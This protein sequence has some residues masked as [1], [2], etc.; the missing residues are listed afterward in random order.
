MIIEHLRS[1]VDRSASRSIKTRSALMF[2]VRQAKVTDLDSFVFIH[3]DVGGLEIAMDDTLVVKPGEPSSDVFRK[4]EE[5][6]P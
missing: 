1:H 4:R 2:D 3:Q 6:I 5:S